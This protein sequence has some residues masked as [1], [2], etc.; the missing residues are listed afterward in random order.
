MVIKLSIICTTMIVF[1]NKYYF[2][3]AIKFKE[4]RE[5]GSMEESEV[6][7]FFVFKVR[8]IGL[9]RL[10]IGETSDSFLDQFI[11]NSLQV[12]LNKYH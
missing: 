1:S 8:L 11:T 2:K 3:L 7:S 4:D 5:F 6:V 12:S 9:A 10:E